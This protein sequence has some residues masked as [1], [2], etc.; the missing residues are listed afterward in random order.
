M[1]EASRP[2][3]GEPSEHVSEREAETTDAAEEEIE[4]LGGADEET[5]EEVRGGRG[6][7]GQDTDP[8]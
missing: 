1:G 3:T 8:Y 4:D 5:V 2:G 6:P 7:L